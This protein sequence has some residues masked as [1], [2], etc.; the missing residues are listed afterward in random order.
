MVVRLQH[1]AKYPGL[2]ILKDV[3]EHKAKRC[4]FADVIFLI[5]SFLFLILHTG[6]LVKAR[7]KTL[8]KSK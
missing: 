4:L 7:G 1:T 8:R 3:G 5:D 6:L 2:M